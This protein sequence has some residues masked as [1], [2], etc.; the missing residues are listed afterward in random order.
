M[1]N[2][3]LTLLVGFVVMLGSVMLFKLGLDK[4][5][6]AEAATSDAYAQVNVDM[7]RRAILY[8]VQSGDTLWSLADRFYG[9]GRRWEEIARANNISNGDGL[10]AGA[11]IKIPLAEQDEF[12]QPEPEQPLP[13]NSYDAVEEAVNAGR[14]GLDEETLDVAMCRMNR[15]EF[16]AGALCVARASEQQTVRL[17]LFDAGNDGTDSPLAVYEAPHGNY[18]RDM[19]SEDLDGD[20]EQEI[21]TV[22]ATNEN[23]CTSRVL[24]WENGRLE[25]VSETPDDPLALLR[26]RGK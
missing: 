2:N 11:I 19:H 12:Q 6:D 23:P 20:G 7:N 24:K 5:T 18:L 10:V 25:V 17:S 8:R 9:Q 13:T 22:W 15:A 1:R 16:P 26:L 21:Y 4:M 3:I 14:F